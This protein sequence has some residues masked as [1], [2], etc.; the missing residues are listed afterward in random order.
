ME[1]VRPH[2]A[3]PPPQPTP[4]PCVS[5]P[6]ATPRR[7]VFCSEPAATATACRSCPKRAGA[8][9]LSPSHSRDATPSQGPFRAARTPLQA[10]VNLRESSSLDPSPERSPAQSGVPSDALSAGFE[11][12][13]PL[14]LSRRGRGPER[15]G[16]VRSRPL[17]V[18]PVRRVDGLEGRGADEQV[19]AGIRLDPRLQA[20]PAVPRFRAE[21]GRA[22]CRLEADDGRRQTRI[23]RL[24]IEQ[25]DRGC[26]R[27]W[28]PGCSPPPQPTWCI[29]R[30]VGLRDRPA[31]AR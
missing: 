1:V 11:T 22:R 31:E 14:V 20:I 13:Q 25:L 16:S 9:P 12:L 24:A 30:S 3:P 7:I 26:S 28:W 10:P 21:V 4:G 29:G 6:G 27:A 8:S 17:R 19:A 15:L 2:D 5:A 23:D 18:P